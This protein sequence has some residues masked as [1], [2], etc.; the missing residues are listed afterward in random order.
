M[1]VPSVTP[2]WI[3][4]L[5]CG[6]SGVGKS[7]VAI[8]LA[9]R[10]GVPLAEADDIVT[11][12]KALTTPEQAPMLHLWDTHPGA[13]RWTPARIVEHTIAVAEEMHRGFEAVIADHIEFATPVVM[14]GDYLLPDLITG[15]GDAVRAVV[16]S[17]PDESRIVANFLSREPG[18][19][20]RFRASVSTQMDAELSARAARVGVPVV[21]AWP[22]SDGL[23]RVDAALASGAE[24]PR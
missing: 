16:V 9:R 19:D 2:P 21:P 3:V 1:R 13:R 6:A 17:E 20:H 15:F 11:A 8:P 10:Y 14:E 24:P 4:T 7:S 18:E 23:G 12:L 5:V 22:R